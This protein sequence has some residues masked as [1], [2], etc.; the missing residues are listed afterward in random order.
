MTLRTIGVVSCAS[1]AVAMH[2]SQ[3]SI[4]AGTAVENQAEEMAAIEE[5]RRQDVAATLSQDLRALADLWTEDGVR[6]VPGAPVDV[7]KEAIRATNERNKAALPELEVESYVPEMKDVTIAGDWAFYW[8]YF[9]AVYVESAGG[10]EKR[11]RAKV[12][13]VQRKQPDGSWKVARGMWTPE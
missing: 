3:G 8:G 11:I 1:L 9:T 4:V 10:E 7:G 13:S 5:F 12:L 6:L 2:I